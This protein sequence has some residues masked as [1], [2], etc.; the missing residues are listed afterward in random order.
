M[1]AEEKPDQNAREMAD[2]IFKNH[3]REEIASIILTVTGAA[4]LMSQYLLGNRPPM[5]DKKTLYG[6]I[7]YYNIFKHLRE[8]VQNP[9]ETKTAL[10]LPICEE[11]G[12][13][14]QPD[15]V[16]SRFRLLIKALY[17]DEFE[18]QA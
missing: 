2:I 12:D 5:S 9:G 10:Y 6:M 16:K 14:C 17:Q 15:D 4:E 7:L 11:A 13:W 18:R 3:S 8:L 1:K